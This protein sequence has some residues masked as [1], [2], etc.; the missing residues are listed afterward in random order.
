MKKT[1]FILITILVSI[2]M[3]G[4]SSNGDSE[5]TGDEDKP[6]LSFGVTNWTSTIPPTKIASKILEDMG[7]KVKETNA[8]AGS[9]Y[10]GLANGDLDIFMDSWYPAQRQYIEKYSDSIES[11]SVSYDDANSGMVVPKY[12]EDIND[13]AD[14]K[15]NEDIVNN[16]MFAIGAGDPAMQDMKKVIDFYNLDIE[17]TNSS[18]AAMLAA[19]EGKMEE[20]EPVLFY[21]WRPHSMFDKYDLKI[22]SNKKA[23]AEKGLFDKSTIHIIANKGLEEKAPKAYKFLSNWSI[24]MEDMEE[25]IAKIDN[26]KDPDDVTQAWIDNHQDK[27]DKMKNGK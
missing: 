5:D 6:T 7:Y 16:E 4:C 26:G 15:G 25:M 11:I 2:A 9:V 3:Y 17:M 19:A 18:E 10:T 20:E 13:V 24:S 21:G 14:L 23:T 27:I 22:L 12:M 8:D 1:L